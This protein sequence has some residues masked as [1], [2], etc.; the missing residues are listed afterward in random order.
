MGFVPLGERHIKVEVGRRES[1]ERISSRLTGQFLIGP[2]FRRLAFWQSWDLAPEHFH[3]L[4]LD[5]GQAGVCLYRTEFAVM[6]HVF[7]TFVQR[8]K[9]ITWPRKLI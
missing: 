9:R 6:V 8:S 3:A 4:F 2:E 7:G 1:V 5:A